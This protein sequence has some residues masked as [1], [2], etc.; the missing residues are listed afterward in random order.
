MEMSLTPSQPSSVVLVHIP[1]GIWLLE[2]WLCDA[3]KQWHRPLDRVWVCVRSQSTVWSDSCSSPC[4]AFCSPLSVSPGQAD[5]LDGAFPCAREAR[6]LAHHEVST[7]VYVI[8]HCIPAKTLAK[9][10]LPRAVVNIGIIPG[11]TSQ[12]TQ[13]RTHTS[14][15]LS[16][17]VILVRCGST[18][19]ACP[20]L[21]TRWAPTGTNSVWLL[22]SSKSSTSTLPCTRHPTQRSP[23]AWPRGTP[24]AKWTAIDAR[25]AL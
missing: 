9:G 6:R 23:P 14:I 20:L 1:H 16:R 25:P 15:H 21:T 7:F 10:S 18:S 8:Q 17:R 24:T 12:A 3:H 5:Q 13:P 2:T 22:S 11:T 4:F 19:T